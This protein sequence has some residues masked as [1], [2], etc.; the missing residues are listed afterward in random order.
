MKR[1]AVIFNQ[2][3]HGFYNRN[4]RSVRNFPNA[5]RVVVENWRGRSWHVEIL[6][7]SPYKINDDFLEVSDTV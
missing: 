3:V 2:A 6:D 1:N 5:L 4:F 7:V